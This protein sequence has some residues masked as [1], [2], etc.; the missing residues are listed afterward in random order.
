MLIILSRPI[1][2]KKRDT[3]LDLI[4]RLAKKGERIAVLLIQDACVSATSTE[5]CN[6]L[7]NNRIDLYVSRADIEARGLIQKTCRGIKTIDYIQWVKLV[8]NEHDKTVSWT[9]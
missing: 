5:C 3:I 7:L 9:S 6:H 8:M 1:N 2:G 4:R